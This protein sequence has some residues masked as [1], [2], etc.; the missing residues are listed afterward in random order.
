MKWTLLET[1]TALPDIAS[2]NQP[3]PMDFLLLKK[4]NQWSVAQHIKYKN[5]FE[6]RNRFCTVAKHK[7]HKSQP[8]ICWGGESIYLPFV[9]QF[10]NPHSTTTSYISVTNN[11]FLIKIKIYRCNAYAEW[12]SFQR[13]IATS[14]KLFSQKDKSIVN[15]LLSLPA[16]TICIDKWIN[17]TTLFAVI[18]KKDDINV[19]FRKGVNA[20]V[21][22]SF[23]II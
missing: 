8:K 11:S 18:N 21:W 6:E 12:S 1:R 5:D 13:P 7:L 23:V 14:G 22:H 19:S 16:F 2:P 3:Q 9:W 17:Y 15:R 20:A 10:L 4:K